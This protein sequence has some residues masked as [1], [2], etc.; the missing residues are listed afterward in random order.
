MS[1]AYGAGQGFRVGRVFTRSFEVLFRHFPL[2]FLLAAVPGLP[3]LYVAIAF[4]RA[5]ARA[6]AAAWPTLA[7]QYLVP[8][9]LVILLQPII[10]AIVLYGT[11][12]DMRGR[13]FGIGESVVK[14]LARFLPIIGLILCQ[15]LIYMFGALLLLIPL[16]IFITMYY[17]ALPVCV[18]EQAG[19]ITSLKRSAQL[20]RGY[21]WPLFGIMCLIG[22]L[23]WFGVG[24]VTGML[25]ISG[26]LLAANIGTF[27]WSS[28]VRAL[29]AIMTAVVY[30]D[31]RVAK[32]G[33][34]TDRIAAVF[35]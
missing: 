31:L 6:L 11:F 24:V 17:V 4:G 30:H 7:L 29:T 20:T 23:S 14:G 28:L 18:L 22:L 27:V 25:A 8:F 19:P 3:N 1:Q 34:D 2:F 13:P 10:E 21:R 32:E 26:G 15:S 12:Q 5:S 9:V 16:F 33:I 35:D